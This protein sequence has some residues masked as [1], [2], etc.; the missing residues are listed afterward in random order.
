M[1]SVSFTSG[2]F[3]SCQVVRN[4]HNLISGFDYLYWFLMRSKTNAASA[5]DQ[6][7]RYVLQARLALDGSGYL[8]QL[9]QFHIAQARELC[10]SSLALMDFSGFP[11]S[12]IIDLVRYS[13]RNLLTTFLNFF[14]ILSSSSGVT[15]CG[16]FYQF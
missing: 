2:V 16:K 14:T 10:D 9:A 4:Y 15:S 6:S 7:L 3:H 1:V 8:S 5:E 13:V 11:R 12:S